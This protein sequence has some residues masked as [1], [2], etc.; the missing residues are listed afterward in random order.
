M[1]YRHAMLLLKSLGTAQNRKI[2][3][4]H[5]VGKEMYG[6]SFANLNRLTKEITKDHALAQELW[7]SGNHDARVLATT[8]ADPLEV[9]PQLLDAWKSDLDNHVIT[10]AFSRLVAKT[11]FA[12]DRLEHWTKS[13]QEWTGRAGWLV[14]ALL[15]MK[16]GALEDEYLE[17]RIPMIEER[18]H[19]AKNRVRDAMNSALIAIGARSAALEEK[20]VAAALHIGKVE[21]DHGRTG[22]KTPDAV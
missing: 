16:D 15:A 9:S 7:R 13:S 11:R 18:I 2:L 14:F 1:T 6:V 5:G 3:A 21:V 4:R 8:V 22:C 17:A 10:D 12:Q 19:K 20:A